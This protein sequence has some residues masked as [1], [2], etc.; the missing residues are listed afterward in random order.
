MSL[1][2][3]ESP[4]LRGQLIS[5]SLWRVTNDCVYHDRVTLVAGTFDYEPCVRGPHVSSDENPRRQAEIPS[6]K[7]GRRFPAIPNR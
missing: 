5:K 6:I 1:I 7:R 2:G 4:D 3:H